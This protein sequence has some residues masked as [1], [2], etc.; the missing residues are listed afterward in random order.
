LWNI[1]R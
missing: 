1:L